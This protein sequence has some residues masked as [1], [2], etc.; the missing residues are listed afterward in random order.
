M[1]GTVH[2]PLYAAG[3]IISA[4]FQAIN[5]ALIYDKTYIVGYFIYSITDWDFPTRTFPRHTIG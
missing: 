5:R 2:R 4:L 1:L 3:D